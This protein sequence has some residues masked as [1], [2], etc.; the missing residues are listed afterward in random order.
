MPAVVACDNA[1][2]TR[3]GMHE[4]HQLIC[5]HGD[6]SDKRVDTSELFVITI[7][8]NKNCMLYSIKKIDPAHNERVA[9]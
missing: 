5:W 7:A 2:S 1:P 3:R 8:I 6:F 4:L 9:I